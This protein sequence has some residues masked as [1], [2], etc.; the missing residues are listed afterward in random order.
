MPI[1]RIN[2]E[3]ILAFSGPLA[4]PVYDLIISYDIGCQFQRKYHAHSRTESCQASQSWPTTGGH[5]D[6]ESVERAWAQVGDSH[7]LAMAMAPRSV[8]IM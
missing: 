4:R 1:T 3:Y 2:E 6:G 5:T 8:V 7:A